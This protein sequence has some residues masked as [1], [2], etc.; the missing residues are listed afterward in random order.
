M[1]SLK[2]EL[3]VRRRE[4]QDLHEPPADSGPVG[5]WCDGVQAVSTTLQGGGQN[6]RPDLQTGMADTEGEV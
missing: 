5:A 4:I 1:A 6:R 3:D 2:E